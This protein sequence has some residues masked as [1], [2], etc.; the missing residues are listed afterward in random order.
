MHGFILIAPL[1]DKINE[2]HA[3]RP[4]MPAVLFG[5]QQTPVCFL[6]PATGRAADLMGG[7]GGGGGG[8]GSLPCK[9]L[10]SW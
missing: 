3:A 7:G 10:N 9:Q 4:Q 8:G 6:T 1:A 2:I 5:L